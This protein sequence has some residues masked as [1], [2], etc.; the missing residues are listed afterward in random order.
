MISY[1][2]G[3]DHF[4]IS[5]GFYNKLNKTV[6]VEET[7]VLENPINAKILSHKLRDMMKSLEGKKDRFVPSFKKLRTNH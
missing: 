3:K 2:E 1:N 7:N 6:S 5:K 4:T